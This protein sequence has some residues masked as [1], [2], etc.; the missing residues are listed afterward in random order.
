MII[1]A[2]VTPDMKL[3]NSA[4]ILQTKLEI[5]NKCTCLDIA[6]A[7]SGFVY[8]VNMADSFIKTG[9]A[10]KNLLLGLKCLAEKLTGLIEVFVFFLVMDAGALSAKLQWENPLEIHAT[11]L[12][13]MAPEKNFSPKNWW[14]SRA[15]YL[16]T[17]KRALL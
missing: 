4:S 6:V 10:K 17:F 14:S 13:Q 1:F 16:N 9:M 5:T 15:Y 2:S 8:G 12:A 7:C 11:H 3:P